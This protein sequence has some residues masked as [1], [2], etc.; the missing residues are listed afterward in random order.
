MTRLRNIVTRALVGMLL[1]IN[2]ASVSAW[3][4]TKRTKSS[5]SR[6][7]LPCAIRM[8]LDGDDVHNNRHMIR[9]DC[10]PSTSTST[11]TISRRNFM[12]D[13]ATSIATIATTTASSSMLTSPS[14]SYAE[15]SISSLSPPGIA[16]P[17]MGLGAWAWGDSLFWGCT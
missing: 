16:L 12:V 3:M 7:S 2:N 8:K 11:S 6:K 1:V 10:P 15:T 4:T 5:S 9:D 17:A 13:S 14:S